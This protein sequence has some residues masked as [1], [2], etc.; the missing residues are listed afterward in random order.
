MV[1]CNNFSAVVGD[2]AR[3]DIRFGVRYSVF[4]VRCYFCFGRCWRPRHSRQAKAGTP[5]TNGNPKHAK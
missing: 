2:S 3:G 5:T 1:E 4:G